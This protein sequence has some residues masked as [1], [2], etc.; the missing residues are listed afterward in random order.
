MDPTH[1]GNLHCW[2]FPL[3]RVSA[4]EGEENSP[5][6]I[7]STTGTGLK[8]QHPGETRTEGVGNESWMWGLHCLLRDTKELAWSEVEG[9]QMQKKGP[10]GWRKG[11]VGIGAECESSRERGTGFKY[12]TGYAGHVWTGG[13]DLIWPQIPRL[14]KDLFQRVFWGFPARACAAHLA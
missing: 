4:Q 2:D 11:T 6:R 10:L 12:G 1:H 9:G 5:R 7:F 13:T 3:R 8:S 14:H